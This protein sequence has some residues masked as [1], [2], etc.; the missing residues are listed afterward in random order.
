MQIRNP[1]SEGVS[2]VVQ[3][4]SVQYPYDILS[5]DYPNEA[6]AKLS[7]ISVS[8]RQSSNSPFVQT[9]VQGV[10]RLPGMT[11]RGDGSVVVLLT[12]MGRMVLNGTSLAPATG[13]LAAMSDADLYSKAAAAPARGG[14][15]CGLPPTRNPFPLS[16][17]SYSWSPTRQKS[18]CVVHQVLS[19]TVT[20]GGEALYVLSAQ[21]RL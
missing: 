20:R 18:A 14:A 12:A 4:A 16:P 15:S 8:I 9:S 21:R 2:Q 13:E 5:S 17:M 1:T 10:A 7:K 6:L 11:L 19:V 3:T